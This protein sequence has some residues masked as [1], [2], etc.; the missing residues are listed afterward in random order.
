MKMKEMKDNERQMK[1][2]TC[3]TK[4]RVTIYLVDIE[5]FHRISEHFDLMM[6]KTLHHNDDKFTF[7][8]F[9]VVCLF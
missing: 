8:F 3:Q 4:V 9:A 1:I 5:I 2:M 6:E 7:T